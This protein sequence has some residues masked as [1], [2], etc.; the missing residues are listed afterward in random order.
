MKKF[1]ISFCIFLSTLILGGLLYF[2]PVEYWWWITSLYICCFL[3]VYG[4]TISR[5]KAAKKSQLSRRIRKIK[6]KTRV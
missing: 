2:L 1:L 3:G 4:I 6:R 5:Q